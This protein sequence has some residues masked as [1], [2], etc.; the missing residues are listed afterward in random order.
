MGGWLGV[1]DGFVDGVVWCDVVLVV[2]VV[3]GGVQFFVGGLYEVV[4]C[5]FVY[6]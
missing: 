4:V 5:C 6:G 1:G 3:F 2:A